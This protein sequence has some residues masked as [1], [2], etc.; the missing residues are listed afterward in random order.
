MA[1][2]YIEN[3]GCRA[4]QADGAA[5]E[6]QFLSRG[7][8]QASTA[9]DAE[10]VILNTCTVTDAADKDARASIRRV[11]RENPALQ[12]YDNLRFCPSDNDQI[13]AYSKTTPDHS[14]VIVCAVNLDP[15]W[16]QSAWLYVPVD[17]WGIAS[18]QP[19]VVHDLLTDERFT[20]RGR[21]NWVR[22]DPHVQPAHVFRIEVRHY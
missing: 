17:E 20:W 18:D 7:I 10:I 1:S 4:T 11:R 2:F 14:N 16:P 13:I 5:I 22:I 3:F 9:G 8:K 21:W 15:F 19:Y 12:L 6:K